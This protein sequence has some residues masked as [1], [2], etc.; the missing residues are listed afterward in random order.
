MTS[1][2]PAVTASAEATANPPR[3]FNRRQA[4]RFAV[5]PMYTEIRARREDHSP[6]M[7]GHIYD[8]SATGIRLELDAPVLPGDA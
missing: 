5:A 4:E 6:E 8:V 7:S 3:H 2:N 1:K